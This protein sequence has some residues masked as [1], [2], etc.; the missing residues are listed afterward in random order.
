MSLC[1][2]FSFNSN[3]RIQAGFSLLE[4]TIV[5]VILGILGGLSLPLLTT[6]LARSAILKTR[7]H[8]E[9]ALQA[10]AAYI[11]KN[12]HFPC[13][14]DP[15]KKGPEFGIARAQCRGDKAKG[16]LPFKTLGMSETYAKDGFK[17]FMIYAIEPE[18]TKK[19]TTLEN[20]PGGFITVKNEEGVS[21]IATPQ[22]NDPS[23]NY[24]A[25]VLISPGKRENNKPTL[26]GKQGNNLVFIENNPEGDILRWESRDV[27]LKHYISF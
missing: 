14:A 18:L 2:F 16:I 21:V 15:Q 26:Q 1:A 17:H 11:E 20:E 9:Y 7:S 13:P 10:I 5:L 3:S 22:K 25:L 8:Q 4:L 12:Q 24:V 27:F 6:Q 19:D 23:P